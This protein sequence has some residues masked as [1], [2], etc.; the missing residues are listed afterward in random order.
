MNGKREIQGIKERGVE[1]KSYYML[2]LVFT[3]EMHHL[4]P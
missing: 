2:G 3:G 4:L 1:G